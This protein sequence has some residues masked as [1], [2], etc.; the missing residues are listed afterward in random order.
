MCVILNASNGSE[1][2]KKCTDDEH[3]GPFSSSATN[4][5]VVTFNSVKNVKSIEVRFNGK[6]GVKGG[7]AAGQIAEFKIS[8]YIT[9]CLKL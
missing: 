8:G 2:A 1:L 6:A 4:E 9:S 5:I 7:S 3:G